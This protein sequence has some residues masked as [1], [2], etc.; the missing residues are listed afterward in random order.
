MGNLWADAIGF[1]AYS[2]EGIGVILPIREV[3]ADKKNYFK[4]LCITVTLIAILY[5]FLGEFTAVAWGDTETFQTLPLITASLPEKS[6]VTYIVKILFSLNLVFSYPLVIHPA[7]LVVESWF[8]GSWAKTRKR[9]MCKNLTRTIIVALS[10]VV[11]IQLYDLLDQFLS[12]TGG[13]TCIPVAFLIPAAVHLEVVAKADN[14]MTSKIIDWCI[15]IIMGGL[16]IFCT[17]K[18]IKDF[19]E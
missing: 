1:S 14:N 15:L 9:Q 11:A 2:Y 4:L 8:F 19:G 17:Y 3:T 18:A 7:N 13:L 6:I 10:C 12:I 16:M 5:I